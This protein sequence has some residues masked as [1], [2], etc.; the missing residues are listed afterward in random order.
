M[1]VV[2]ALELVKEIHF[3]ATGSQV[4]AHELF[5]MLEITVLLKGYNAVQPIHSIVKSF[6]TP[7]FTRT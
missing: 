2:G 3:I 5:F 7:A 4:G 6:G 1:V